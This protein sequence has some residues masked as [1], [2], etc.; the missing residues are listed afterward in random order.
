MDLHTFYTLLTLTFAAFGLYL[1]GSGNPKTLLRVAAIHMYWRARKVW[2]RVTGKPTQ[3]L[4]TR[5]ARKRGRQ[6]TIKDRIYV[7]PVD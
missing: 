5:F 2:R 7:F 6:V 3:V 4:P 1:M